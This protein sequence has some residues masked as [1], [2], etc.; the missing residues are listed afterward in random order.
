MTNCAI[1]IEELDV[2]EWNY[3][4]S[5][6]KTIYRLTDEE[7]AEFAD[8]KTAKIIAAIPFVGGCCRPEVEK[9]SIVVD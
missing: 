5:E 2:P 9:L 6:I 3:F 7:A 8:S 1:K 4:V